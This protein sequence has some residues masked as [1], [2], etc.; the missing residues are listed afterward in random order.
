MEESLTIS[1]D[2]ISKLEDQ[3]RECDDRRDVRTGVDD[4]NDGFVVDICSDEP[5]VS[6]VTHEL[7]LVKHELTKLQS[8]LQQKEK[9][10]T[11]VKVQ[12]ATV[13]VAANLENTKQVMITSRIYPC[14]SYAYSGGTSYV[15]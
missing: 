3:V 4:V 13:A 6:E 2:R 11:E 12:H 1:N 9:E 5:T 10:L 8:I 14:K 7:S 15:P